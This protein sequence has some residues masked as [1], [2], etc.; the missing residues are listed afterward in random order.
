MEQAQLG[1]SALPKPHPRDIAVATGVMTWQGDIKPKTLIQ[2]AFT[3][4]TI[5]KDTSHFALLLSPFS[6]SKS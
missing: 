2:Q 5:G 1:I 4:L 3:A 6:I